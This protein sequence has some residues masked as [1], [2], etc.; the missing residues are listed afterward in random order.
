MRLNGRVID[1]EDCPAMNPIEFKLEEKPETRL[2]VRVVEGRR[3]GWLLV[4]DSTVN[5]VGR[6]Y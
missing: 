6:Q 3:V 2:W 1:A 4:T 5:I